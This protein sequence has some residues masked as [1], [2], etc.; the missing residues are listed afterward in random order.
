M[1]CFVIK[2]LFIILK[3]TEG[4]FRPERIEH[5]A[6]RFGLGMIIIILKKIKKLTN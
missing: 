1:N 2:Y 4:N 5:I 6:Q 3:D